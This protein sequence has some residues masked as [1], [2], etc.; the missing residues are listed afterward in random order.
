[1]IFFIPPL[2][3]GESIFFTPT[4]FSTFLM[5]FFIPPL[6][7]REFTR[8]SWGRRREEGRAALFLRSIVFNIFQL[9][10]SNIFF[11]TLNVCCFI[12]FDHSIWLSGSIYWLLCHNFSKRV[13]VLY[14]LLL[15]QIPLNVPKFRELYMNLIVD[16]N[17]QTSRSRKLLPVVCVRLAI[18]SIILQFLC[19]VI[20]NSPS[21][22]LSCLSLI[23][24]V[25]SRHTLSLIYAMMKNN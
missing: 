25:V 18:I 11:S 21:F 22:Y 2:F 10:Q 24:K 8:K 12:A 23:E 6:F 9:Y 15:F 16:T 1:M 13:F 14:P 17:T 3:F 4:F 5:N 19:W 20:Q 7:F